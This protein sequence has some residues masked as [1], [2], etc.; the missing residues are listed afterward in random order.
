VRSNTTGSLDFYYRILATTG[1]GA[2]GRTSTASFAVAPLRV[3]YRSDGLGTVV[4][5]LAKRSPVPGALITFVFDPALSCAR[6]QE[7]RFILIRTPAKKFV[8]G[9]STRVIATTGVLVSLPTVQP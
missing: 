6:H 3:A 4:P 8:A 1:S 9:G 7:S 5:Q 2:I